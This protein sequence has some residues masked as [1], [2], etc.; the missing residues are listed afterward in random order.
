M[1]ILSAKKEGRG[2]L[3]VPPIFIFLA[4]TPWR[5]QPTLCVETR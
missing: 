3:D 4:L 1:G 2:F 5:F